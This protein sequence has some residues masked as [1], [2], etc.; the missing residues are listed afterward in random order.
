MSL[1]LY[2]LLI[3]LGWWIFK[4]CLRMWWQW[5][6][7][8]TRR[9]FEDFFNQQS[10]H[11]PPPHTHQEKPRRPKRRKKIDPEVGEYIAF[12]E[13]TTIKKSTPP[14]YPTASE[15]QVEDAEFEDL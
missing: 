1:L 12:E 11:Q 8:S 10:G 6:L 5:K 7:N 4:A 14:P 3:V 2:I 13:V 9:Q 15:E